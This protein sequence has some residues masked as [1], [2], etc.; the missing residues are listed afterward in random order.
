MR[1]DPVLVAVNKIFNIGH[2]KYHINRVKHILKDM[3]GLAEQTPNRWIRILEHRNDNEECLFRCG[4]PARWFWA[5]VHLNKNVAGSQ[6]REEFT[7]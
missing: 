2:L 3:G 5:L 6:H 4:S 7:F 1:R